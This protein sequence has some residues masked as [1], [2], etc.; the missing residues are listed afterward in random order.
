MGCRGALLGLYSGGLRFRVRDRMMKRQRED[1][2]AEQSKEGARP[3]SRH[4]DRDPSR[5]GHAPL[6][7]LLVGHPQKQPVAK[8]NGE[9]AEGHNHESFK[10]AKHDGIHGL[11]RPVITTDW[12]SLIRPRPVASLWWL[13][14]P[15]PLYQ[16][17]L[18]KL[19]PLAC[20]HSAAKLKSC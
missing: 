15:S 9:P 2:G 17:R 18:P 4:V 6:R 8:V 13:Q 12:P 20:W 3:D 5:Q 7:V 19:R 1:D 14:E 11:H 10:G 16:V